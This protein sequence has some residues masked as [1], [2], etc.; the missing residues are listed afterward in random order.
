MLVLGQGP[1]LL[2]RKGN[3]VVWRSI[4][5][6]LFVPV[7][8]LPVSGRSEDHIDL[9]ERLDQLLAD[10][11]G[12]GLPLPPDDVRL[13]LREFEDGTVN[14]ERQ[15]H[16]KLA[17]R[18]GP[19]EKPNTAIYWLGCEPTAF[20]G[21]N[22]DQD[23]EPSADL[24]EKTRA[25]DIDHDQR[26]FPPYPDL[27]LAIQCHARGWTELAGALLDRSR[28]TNRSNESAYW[29]A[30]PRDDR[31]A[32]GL[33]AWNYWCRRFA[34]SQVDRSPIV[35][36]LQRLIDGKF[37][38]DDAAHRN[39]VIDMA[40]TLVPRDTEP[41]SLDAAVESLLELQIDNAWPVFEDLFSDPGAE[42]NPSFR[43]L[44][45]AGLEAVPTLIKHLHDFRLTRSVE[46]HRFG[47]SWHIRIADVVA[48]LLNGL[49][50]EKFAFDFR[51]NEGRGRALDEAHVL[52]WWTE[53]QGEKALDYL[54]KSAVAADSQGRRQGNKGILRALAQR[55]PDEFLRLFEEQLK[56]DENLYPFFETLRQS[57]VSQEQKS[58]I[59]LI[60]V[61]H[62]DSHNRVSAL[63]QLLS[64]QHPDAVPRL[65]REL[66]G[67]P[68]TPAVPYWKSAAGSI[69][70]LVNNTDD[71]RAWNAFET[72]ARRVDVG[73]RLEM[74][75]GL[76]NCSKRQRD[77]VIAALTKFLDDDSVR[78]I[79]QEPAFLPG[80]S[81]E[82]AMERMNRDL[83]SGPCA[84]FFF[85]RLA[86]RDFAAMQLAYLLELPVNVHSEWTAHE[87]NRLR[88]RVR[89][90]LA[91]RP[92][93][94]S[95][96]RKR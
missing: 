23:A 19:G 90:A 10:Y 64:M 54:L 24:V 27:A 36:Q 55:F 16:L 21:D 33:L 6:L 78:D 9:C 83:F 47:Y 22:A 58:R 92:K 65:L 29:G 43:Q 52:H 70:E 61:Q 60:G 67:I 62:K 94:A 84:G 57:E 7:I 56:G 79:S 75:D 32:V 44:Q 35:A 18:V 2:E 30:R 85:H 93:G 69:A 71:V 8:C 87:W 77:R 89:G 14:G 95:E 20:K 5:I 86:V 49:N 26:V 74:I 53:N 88:E 11:R 59:L 4:R 34:R 68:R 3:A 45:G 40:A 37:V 28:T 81:A 41:G 63:R 1:G 66:D 46:H 50:P 12:H 76:S 13:V 15:F 38:A 96:E 51:A 31:L 42:R 72:T 25:A 48:L 82:K 17:F 80:E 73:Q 91:E 39:V